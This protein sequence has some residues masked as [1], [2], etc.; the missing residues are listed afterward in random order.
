[1]LTGQ[2]DWE[3]D[4]HDTDPGQNPAQAP[5]QVC[6]LR[7][8]EGGGDRHPQHKHTHAAELTTGSL[9]VFNPVL[10]AKVAISDQS[11]SPVSFSL[12]VCCIISFKPAVITSLASELC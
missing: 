8:D 1:M 10:D 3:N 11:P 12:V 6:G 5:T 7:G 2:K 9:R 4:E